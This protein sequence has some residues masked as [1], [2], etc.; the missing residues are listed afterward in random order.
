MRNTLESTAFFATSYSWH[1]GQF[2]KQIQSAIAEERESVSQDRVNE[3]VSG[4]TTQTRQDIG[5]RETRLA[6]SDIKSQ[7]TILSTQ[8]THTRGW[9]FPFAH[10]AHYR[11]KLSSTANRIRED[12]RTDFRSTT[13]TALAK[14]LRFVCARVR[15]ME[16]VIFDANQIY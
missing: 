8:T 12:L 16:F 5:N 10:F 6:L 2:N 13:L 14:T 9:V 4:N 11:R 15:H 1:P 3:W 7:E